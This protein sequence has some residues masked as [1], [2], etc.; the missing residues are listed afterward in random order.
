MARSLVFRPPANPAVRQALFHRSRPA[1]QIAVQASNRRQRNVAVL[2]ALAERVVCTLSDASACAL[3]LETSA[4][5]VLIIA[6]RQRH[7]LRRRQLVSRADAADLSARRMREALQNQQFVLTPQRRPDV[8]EVVCYVPSAKRRV[9][10]A[11][12][13]VPAVRARKGVD[14]WW[15]QTA[16]PLGRRRFRQLEVRGALRSLRTC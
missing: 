10:V 9:L 13:L 4:R 3:G 2:L 1:H 11:H 16:H 5:E 8:Y 6:E 14:E 7:I 15:I 12:K